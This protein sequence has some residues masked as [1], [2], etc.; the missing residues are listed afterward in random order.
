MKGFAKTAWQNARPFGP[1]FN[2]TRVI[3]KIVALLLLTAWSSWACAHDHLRDMAFWEDPTGQVR[4]EQLPPADAFQPFTELLSEGYTASRY[5]IRLSIDPEG[6]EGPLILRIRPNYLDHIVLYDPAFGSLG[7][8]A[9]GD[10]HPGRDHYESLN[11]NFTLPAGQAPRDIWL[12][13]TTT[14]SL[15]FAAGVYDL[16]SAH[17]LDLLQQLQAG[18][19]L[20]I[21]GLFIVWGGFQFWATRDRV[22]GLFVLKQTLCLVYMAGLLGYYRH[23]WPIGWPITPGTFVDVSMGPYVAAAFVFEYYFLRDYRPNRFLLTLLRGMPAFLPVYWLLLTLGQAHA[24][25]T[26]CMLL[27]VIGP[28][29]AFLMTLTVRT[30]A[31]PGV[32][33]PVPRLSRRALILTYGAILLGSSLITWPSLGIAFDRTRVFDGQ[34]MYSLI[35]GLALLTLLQLRIRNNEQRR[36]AL[37]I[38]HHDMRQRYAEEQQRR[39]EQAQFL[40]MLTH[41]LRTPLSVVSMALANAEQPPGSFADAERSIEDMAAILERCLTVDQLEGGRMATRRHPV[42]AVDT[43]RDLIARSADPSAIILDAPANAELQTDPTLFRLVVA[44][45]LDNALKYRAA[46]APVAVGVQASDSQLTLTVANPPGKAGW[47][48]PDALFQKYYRSPRAQTLTGTGLGLYLAHQLSHSL[49][50]ELAYAPTATHVR[51]RLC[52]PR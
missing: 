25:F 5:W 46:D 19:Y 30:E 20:A 42:D 52:L 49:G 28:I 7:R 45:L 38:Q 36:I 10:E 50:G 43:V 22:V 8:E 14:S 51:F 9:R 41:E 13:V 27:V 16:E 33:N 44:N 34:L 17:A 6:S 1:C 21:I 39:E 47:P 23:V 31:E 15:L 4:F 32:P 48:D 2:K 3:R 11:I 24:A 35:S 40:A 26:L 29:L 18:F 12:R 37:E